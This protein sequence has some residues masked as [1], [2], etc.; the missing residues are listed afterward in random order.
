MGTFGRLVFCKVKTQIVGKTKFF[1]SRENPPVQTGGFPCSLSLLANHADHCHH[2]RPDNCR[3]AAGAHLALCAVRCFPSLSQQ[4][5]RTEVKQ[6]TQYKQYAYA[7]PIIDLHEIC[8]FSSF[9]SRHAHSFHR[10]P[11]G[12]I[13]RHRCIPRPRL[14][15]GTSLLLTRSHG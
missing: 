7:D 14:L 5:A 9:P 10:C 15:H 13:R 3:R 6:D 12:C 4:P 8:P 1:D 11:T 2:H